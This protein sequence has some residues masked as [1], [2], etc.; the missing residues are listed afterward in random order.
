MENV[1]LAKYNT[2]GN[3]IKHRNN[4]EMQTWSYWR[5]ID[6][7]GHVDVSHP[8]EVI[9]SIT[10]VVIAGNLHEMTKFRIELEWLDDVYL[11]LHVSGFL[12]SCCGACDMW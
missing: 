11:Y 4:P 10:E 2:Q 8:E 5:D 1:S 6:Y 7:D 9:F 3:M 12:Y